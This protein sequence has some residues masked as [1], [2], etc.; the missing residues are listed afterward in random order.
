[1][2]AILPEPLPHDL[3]DDLLNKLNGFGIAGFLIAGIEEEWLDRSPC[4]MNK[5]VEF[6][7]SL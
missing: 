5:F 6:S 1:M 2:M 7:L 3:L 4:A